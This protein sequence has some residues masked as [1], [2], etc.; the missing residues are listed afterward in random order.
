MKPIYLTVIILLLHSPFSSGQWSTQSSGIGQDIYSIF[1]ID[2]NY[3][4]AVGWN[5]KIVATTNGG[6]NWTQQTSGITA[7]LYDVFFISQAVGWI[8]GDGG[9]L[10]K[11]TNGGG[12]WVQLPAFT[13]LSLLSV[14][15]VDQNTGWVC[16][17]QGKV[18]TT[19]NGGTNWTAQSTGLSMN[20]A[21]FS[22]HFVNSQTGWATG[23]SF[24]NNSCVVLKTTNGGANWTRQNVPTSSFIRTSSFVGELVG[25]SVCYDGTIIKTTNG[26]T[27]WNLTS[28]PTTDWLY[29]GFFIDENTGW[30][31]TGYGG[32]YKTT[33]GGNSWTQQSSGSTSRINSLHFISPS[34]GWAG[35]DGGKILKHYVLLSSINLLSPNGKEMWQPGS[36]RTISWGSSYV[37]NVTIDYSTNSGNTWIKIIDSY[38][39]SSNPYNWN[40]P[41]TPSAACV[42]R[43]CDSGNLSIKDLSDSV[44]TILNPAYGDV[45]LN[46]NVQAYDASVILKYLTD[47]ITLNN[48]QKYNANVSGDTTISALDASLILRYVTGLT[49]TLP[50]LFNKPAF[51]SITFNGY[52]SLPE[53]E[54]LIPLKLISGNNILSFEG[55]IRYNDDQLI[56]K[57][58]EWCGCAES[59]VKQVNRSQ[60]ILRFACFTTNEVPSASGTIAYL[61]FKIIRRDNAGGIFLQ[62]IRINEESIKNEVDSLHLFPT[63]VGNEEIPGSGCLLEQNYPNPFNPFTTIKYSIQKA[64]VTGSATLIQSVSLKVYDTIGNEVANLVAE[65]QPAGDYEVKF[66]GSALPSGVYFYKLQ[67]NEFSITKKLLLTK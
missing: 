53:D 12:N 19:T 57:G 50:D 40:V 55:V 32:I 46:S 49:D 20:E 31:G 66:N 62:Q 10:L 63:S 7:V 35:C 16:G 67:V 11:T 14:I 25:Y 59:F 29:A 8:A 41:N 42:I 60:N 24:V 2:T 61:K 27:N 54:I 64:M 48:E 4:W 56:Y 52:M 17:D 44:F 26:G 45:D 5:G 6:A 13:N 58:I 15:F 65:N 43:I 22:I 36:N 21:L 39:A 34:T 38:P 23:G 33:N 28:S 51:G 1:F 47:I 30:I 3:G 18:F 37:A 9:K